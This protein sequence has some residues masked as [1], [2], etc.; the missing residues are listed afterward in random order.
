MPPASTTYEARK[1]PRSRVTRVAP[2][3]SNFTSSTMVWV[4]AVTP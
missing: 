3:S 2:S 4:Y 1:V